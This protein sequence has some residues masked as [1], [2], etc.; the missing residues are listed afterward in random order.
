[1]SHNINQVEIIAISK[2]KSFNAWRSSCI[3]IQSNKTVTSE[4][5]H[6][7]LSAFNLAKPGT[8]R[9]AVD[10]QT[11]VH[12]MRKSGMRRPGK[13]TGTPLCVD[14]MSYFGKGG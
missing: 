8:E 14:G 13:L 1:M 10:G 3:A 11:V 9:S 12:N 4:T 7:I 5:T 6:L 2:H